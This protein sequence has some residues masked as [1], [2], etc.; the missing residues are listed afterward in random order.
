MSEATRLR[1]DVQGDEARGDCPRFLQF[2][3]SVSLF[4]RQRE[5]RIWH[6]LCR[7]D[8]GRICVKLEAHNQAAA[9]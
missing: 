6:H 5:G 1:H 2:Y 7:D 4:M 9:P 8:G 3:A